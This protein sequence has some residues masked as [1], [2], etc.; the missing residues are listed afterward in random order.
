MRSDYYLEDFEED[1]RRKLKSGVNTFTSTLTGDVYKIQWMGGSGRSRTGYTL[2]R[3][4]N[5][6]KIKTT[7]YACA[8]IIWDDYFDHRRR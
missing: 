3:N 5:A 7:L 4:G 2:F 6:I 1:L 8:S